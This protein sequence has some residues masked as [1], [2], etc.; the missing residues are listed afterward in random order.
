MSRFHFSLSQDVILSKRG[1]SWTIYCDLRFL[2]ADLFDFQERF[3]WWAALRHCFHRRSFTELGSVIAALVELNQNV[4]RLVTF[5]QLWVGG[6]LSLALQIS[7]SVTPCV[8]PEWTLTGTH[9]YCLKYSGLEPCCGWQWKHWEETGCHSCGATTSP[10][11][12]NPSVHSS[13]Y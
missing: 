2:I 13:P 11:L 7:K 10:L 3:R 12:I 6:S 8:G 5:L 1:E 9:T 4:P